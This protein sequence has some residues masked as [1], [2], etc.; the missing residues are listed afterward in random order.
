MSI[1]ISNSNVPGVRNIFAIWLHVM[2]MIA[3]NLI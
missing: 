1:I 3:R 2:V